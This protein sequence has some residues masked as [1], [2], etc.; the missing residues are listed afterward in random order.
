MKNFR[1]LAVAV[2]ITMTTS[3]LAQ[4]SET[5]PF[6]KNN[7][8]VSFDFGKLK[9][10]IDDN[11]SGATIGYSRMFD[12]SAKVPAFVETGVSLRYLGLTQDNYNGSGITLT[13]DVTISTL[14]IPVSIGYNLAIGNKG[15]S[16]APYAG[17]NL[18]YHAKAET[19]KKIIDENGTEKSTN[20]WFE[21][22]GSHRFQVGWQVGAHV[23][24][25]HFVAGV[26]YGDTFNKIVDNKEGNLQ[27]NVTSISLGYRF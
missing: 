10:G 23:A 16:I 6:G 18:Q 14:K 3:A 19:E 12:I 2:L 8:Y 1:L 22:D 21:V 5:F 15:F 27:I 20:S 26:S 4:S 25:K 17:F 9:G 24:Y 11:I 13:N 7:L